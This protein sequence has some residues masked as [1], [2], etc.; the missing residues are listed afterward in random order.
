LHLQCCFRLPRINRN[1]SEVQDSTSKLVYEYAQFTGT[2]RHVY[3][4]VHEPE[5]EPNV[6]WRTQ[7]GCVVCL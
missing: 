4:V 1:G 6:T 2:D 7:C 5:N 3:A